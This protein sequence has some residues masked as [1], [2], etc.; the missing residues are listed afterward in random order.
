MAGYHNP[1]YILTLEIFSLYIFALSW[2]KSDGFDTS[3]KEE[4]KRKEK[5]KQT[6]KLDEIRVCVCVVFHLLTGEIPFNL[7]KKKTKKKETIL[8]QFDF[9]F[10]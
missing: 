1:L 5:N 8:S 9:F 7:K 3:G 2:P 6:N 10:G 4:K